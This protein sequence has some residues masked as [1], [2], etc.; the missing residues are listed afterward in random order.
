MNTKIIDEAFEFIRQL[1]SWN[2]ITEDD[3]EWSDDPYIDNTMAD[4]DMMIRKARD[5]TAAANPTE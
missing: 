5:I 4:L 2:T 3:W 1:A